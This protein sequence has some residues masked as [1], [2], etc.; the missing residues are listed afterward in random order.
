MFDGLDIS[1]FNCNDLIIVFQALCKFRISGVRASDLQRVCIS[2]WC[3]HL[4]TLYSPVA[5]SLTSRKL[6]LPL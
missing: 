1:M 2:I 6:A 4:E 3:M 5:Q